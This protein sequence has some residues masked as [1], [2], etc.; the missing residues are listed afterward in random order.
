MSRLIDDLMDVSRVRL[1]N[2]ELH[3]QEVDL[4]EVLTCAVEASSLLAAPTSSR[5]IQFE[6]IAAPIRVLGDHMR[7]IQVLENLFNNAAKYTDADGTITVRP[8]VEATQ[9]V[10][11]ISD[12]G[13]GIAPDQL[14]S[15]FE[16]FAQAG[17]ARTPRSQGGL[18]IGLHLARQLV[19][20]HCG[21]LSAAS[22][23]LGC[24]STFTVRLPLVGTGTTMSALEGAP[25]LLQ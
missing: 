22:D 4:G 21:T 14:D 6:P 10:I 2:L 20:S 13:I 16:L 1:G 18:G 11:Q 23:G 12:T 9:A 3:V 15:I 7:L 17:Q 19:Q 5:R 24:G 25:G 8:Y